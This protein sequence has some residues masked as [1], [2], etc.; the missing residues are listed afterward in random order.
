MIAPGFAFATLTSSDPSAAGTARVQ[1]AL[2]RA[3]S[4]LDLDTDNVSRVRAKVGA[5]LAA[6]DSQQE[7]NDAF[8]LS[9][10]TNLSQIQDLD[11]AEATSDLNLFKL[12]LD[13]AQLSFVKLQGLS[14]FNYIS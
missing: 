1:S 8:T 9:T 2:G 14:L 11:F 13:A 7:S 5:R 10:K 6:L 3:L 12:G 4:E